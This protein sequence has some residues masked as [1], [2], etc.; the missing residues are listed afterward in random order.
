MRRAAAVRLR[1]ATP[2]QPAPAP[3]AWR[4]TLWRALDGAH[5]PLEQVLAPGEQAEVR[6]WLAWRE[7]LQATGL[8][9]RGRAAGV[10]A[11]PALEGTRE[12]CARDPAFAHLVARAGPPRL[13]RR[14]GGF[15]TLASAIVHQQL[16][17]R[18][19][20]TIWARLA[21]ALGGRVTAASVAAAPTAMLRAAGL[22]AAKAAALEDLS[23][24][25]RDGRLEPRRLAR[26]PD[27]EVVARLV[28]VRGIG[29]WSAHMHLL[30]GLG[31]MD[32]WPVGDLGVRQG[33]ARWRGLAALPSP[34][35]L[36]ALGEPYR[37]WRSLLAWYAWRAVEIGYP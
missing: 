37:P 21:R 24:H 23:A 15:A 36:E 5:A 2:G 16:S 14:G 30:F 25:V 29:P 12:L 7:A 32:V 13:V 22:S 10:G 35:A 19:A 11:G 1:T 9:P 33:I 3:G 26:L 4:R 17:G 6:A 31:R 18:A 20:A 34:R 8:P 27:E 28:T